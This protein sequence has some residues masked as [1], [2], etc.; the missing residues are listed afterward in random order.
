MKLTIL[1][2]SVLTFQFAY[3]QQYDYTIHLDECK[4]DRL[5]VEL[6]CPGIKGDTVSFNFPMT[7]PGTYAILDYGKYIQK[8]SA[9]DSNGKKLKIQK[10]TNNTFLIYPANDLARI[11]YHV[12]DS[13]DS[14]QKKNKIFEPA[15][16]GFQAEE[17]FY[18]NA[19]G[20]M[21]FLNNELMLPFQT[22]YIRPNQLIGYTSLKEVARTSS[23]QVFNASNYH[24]LIDNPILFTE[25]KEQTLQIQGTK[26]SIASY[27][28]ESDSSAFYVKSKIDSAMVAI[29]QFVEGKLPVDKYSFLNYVVDLKEVGEMLMKGDIGLFGYLKLYRKLGGQGFGALEHG[30]S[31]SYYLPDFGH[32]SYTGMLYETAIHE[33]LHIYS[34]LSL[35]S[36]YIGDFNYIKPIMSKHLWLYEGTTE[37]FSVLVAM[38]GKLTSIDATIENNIKG[39]IE[40]ALLYPDS[41]SFT[42]MSA[43][44]FDKPYI[45][46]YNQVYTRGAIMAMLLDIQ[47]ME[48]TNGQ[49]TLKSVIF[50]LCDKYGSKKS[51]NEETF[52]AEFVESVHPDLQKFFDSYITGTTPLAIEEG[53]SKIGISFQKEKKGIVPIDILSMEDN[54]VKVNR[55]VVVNNS[56]TVQKA[57]KS[58]I[59]GLVPGDK[60]NVTDAAKCFQLA[61]GSY[62]AEGTLVTI[63]VIRKG[64]TVPLTFP[65]KFKN[66]VIK[67]TIEV[68][69]EMT[70]EQ[71]KFF[72]IWSAGK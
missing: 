28:K 56:L 43:N 66:G 42:K 25:E 36:A 61:D 2:L 27:Y 48:L 7:I 9:F 54:K 19:G 29:D 53:F 11:T 50:D 16:T 52:I 67:N 58:N 38:Q 18:I 31:S 55:N 40:N 15:G 70:P 46:L 65:A 68:M 30:N 44:V 71:E 51:F 26:V 8:L 22:T 3:S 34:P 23:S 37:Y 35:H 13:W 45:D 60:V 49:K 62:V 5:L 14:K 59:V 63:N 10:S 12:E 4:K 57:D 39:K 21:G 20:I 24:D 32:H 69:K 17:Y 64:K 1:I 33:F 47:I 41:I 6:T 72:N